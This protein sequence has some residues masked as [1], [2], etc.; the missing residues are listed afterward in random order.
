V[1]A[2]YGWLCSSICG[3]R[4]FPRSYEVNGCGEAGSSGAPPDKIILV[5]YDR[6]IGFYSYLKVAVKLNML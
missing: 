6:A 5:G 4:S 2:S 1:V 3:V